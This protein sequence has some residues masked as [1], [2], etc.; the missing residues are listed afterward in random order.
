MITL[1]PRYLDTWLSLTETAC[2][3]AC[4]RAWEAFLSLPCTVQHAV[5]GRPHYAFLARSRHLD[6]GYDILLR[7]PCVLLCLPESKTSLVQ[8]F[9][10]VLPTSSPLHI[11]LTAS[12]EYFTPEHAFYLFFLPLAAHSSLPVTV[13]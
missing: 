7:E 9:G 1:R 11:S 10:T 6:A 2:T 4:K 5:Y 13:L 8:W 3:D 12:D